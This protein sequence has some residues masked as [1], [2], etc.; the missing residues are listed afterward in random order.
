M[1]YGKASL[2]RQ[3]MIGASAISMVSASSIAI[4]QDAEEDEIVVTGIRASLQKSMDLKRNSAGVVD[5]IT[6]E[7]I[8]V[9]PDTNLAESLQRI[10]GVTIDRSLGEGS[11]VTVRGWGADFNLVT[12]N[13]RVM[14]TSTLGGGAAAP[15]SRSF[16]FGNLASEAVAS[17][18]IY[19]TSKAHISSGGA[20]ATLNIRTTRPLESPGQSGTIGVKGVYDTSQNFSDEITPEISGLYTN[21][22]MDDRLGVAVSASYQERSGG[23]RQANVGW[24]DGYL[25]D[26]SFDNEWGRLATNPSHWNFIDGV[27]NA[28][29]AGD[30]Y[31]VPQNADYEVAEFNRERIN[32]QVTLQF[33]PTNDIR[34]TADYIYAEN[35]VE[36]AQNTAGIWFNHEWTNSSWTDGP[37]AG[38]EYYT[39]FFGATDLSYSGALTANKTELNSFGGNIA[40]DVSD[41]LTLG[42]DAHSSKSE[43]APNNK[44]GSNMSLGTTVVGVSEQSINFE[45]G[46]PIISIVGGANGLD[47]EDVANREISGSAFRNATMESQVDQIQF[48]GSYEIDQKFI[49]SV[50]FGAG[51]LKNDINRAFGFLQ[52][53]AWGGELGDPT[54]IPDDVFEYVELSELF[55][56][57]DNPGMLQGFYRFD[58]ATLADLGE[59][60]YGICSNSW[61]GNNIG[62][63]CLAEQTTNEFL[64]EESLSAYIQFNNSFEMFGRDANLTAGL[65][66]EQTDIT[67]SNTSPVFTGTSWTGNN[68]FFLDLGEGTTI[69][70]FDGSY[71][72]FLPSID[73]DM[74][75]MENVKL[76]ASYS[77]TFGRQTYDK[78]AGT[79]FS[80]LFRVVEGEASSGNPG[81]LPLTSKNYDASLE[82]YYDDDS[83]IS[84][85]A[86][87]K[88]I[89]NFTTNGL[90]D[91]GTLN[92]IYH[93][94]NGP[95]AD[96]ARAALGAGAGVG[97]IHAYICGNFTEGVSID[98]NS[99]ICTVSGVAA[100]DLVSFR[101]TAPVVS[102]RTNWFRGLEF[103]VQ[104]MFGDSGFGFIA[105]YTIADSD[106]EYDNT[107]SFREEQFALPGVSDSA[108]L[109]G[110]YDKNGMQVRLAYAWR[111]MFLA[112]GTRNPFYIESYDQLDASASYD[113]NETFSVFAEGIDI[114]G[115]NT[116]GHRRSRNTA[117]FYSNPKPRYAAGVRYKF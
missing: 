13:D 116:R 7:D 75:P 99:G 109:V 78:L 71:D 23:V 30:V 41:R 115:S 48:T 82:Y 9:F 6:A 98:P 11:T 67:S 15:S 83:Y 21:T 77:K 89:E 27:Q 61:N 105:N 81:L 90:I 19:K 94:Y 114:T 93:P 46:L 32:G 22:F 111:D 38:P 52:T 103:A 112:G 25:G 36:V 35:Q 72:Y 102:D 60:L 70:D 2:L 63:T 5:S 80:S 43:S 4:A 87:H 100:D 3:L 26:A 55:N 73:F 31:A 106:I 12:I 42:L 18:E 54:D 95:R 24:R 37:V 79:N 66:Y 84:V 74:Q 51:Y 86:F 97:D 62:D 96:A 110:I 47:P 68:E 91:P 59:S 108:N 85:G 64:Q 76:R 101:R 88:D 113:I 92:G 40:W 65:R 16:D 28:P 1:K 33:E 29:G 39:E 10:P 53:D 107:L 49:D 20:G 56:N 44:Y 58:F 57:V 117:T 104:H 69:N 45:N 14:P 17:V 8:G 50:D 34:M